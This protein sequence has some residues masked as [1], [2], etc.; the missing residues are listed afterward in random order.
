MVPRKVKKG[1]QSRLIAFGL[2]HV[3]RRISTG[4]KSMI[5]TR[6]ELLS[7]I[8]TLQARLDDVEARAEAAEEALR[9]IQSGEVDAL[10]VYGED[11]DHVYT[12]EG[13]DRT[14]RVMVESVQ[15]GVATLQAEGMLLYA[16]QRLA[17]ML[18]VPLE[19]LLGTSLVPFIA[20]A[21]QNIY[22]GLLRKGKDGL[23]KG[24]M[25]LRRQDGSTFPALLSLSEVRN[26][27]KRVICLVATDL[28]EQ[29]R[30]EEILA[31]E[32]LSRSILEQASEAVVVCDLQ[33]MI[34]R[35]N[36]ATHD[37]ARD[38]P[39]FQSFEKIF[40]LVLG[41]REDESVD[42]SIGAVIGGR[43]F[44][45]IEARLEWAGSS[46]GGPSRIFYLLLSATPLY[47]DRGQVTGCVI[48]LVDITGRT[49][50]EDALKESEKKYR[51]LVKYA[52][53]GI[54]EIDFR[55]KKFTSVNDA[56]CQLSG[57]TRDELLEMNPFDLLDEDGRI[58]FQHRID[59]CLSGEK[60]DE[61][62]EYRV[63][64]KDG[65]EI[66]AI[67]D[68]SF[69][70]DENGKPVI[71]TVIGTDITERKKAEQALLEATRRAEENQ[72]ILEAVIQQMPAGIILSDALGTTAKNNTAMDRIWRRAMLR[73][74]NPQQHG[75]RAFH[76]DGREYEL[77]EWPLTRAL[78]KGEVTLGEEM[79]ILRGDGTQGTVHVS[80]APIRDKSGKIIAG[81]VIDVD[82]SER[83]EMEEQLAYQAGL[84]AQVQD[85]VIANDEQMRITYWNKVAE[86]TFGW[87]EAEALGKDGTELLQIQ[88]PG[89]LRAS[90]MQQALETGR[91]EGEALFRRKDGVYIDVHAK[92]T[93]MKG[94]HGEFKGLVTSARDITR[95]KQAENALRESEQLYRAIGESIDYG[96]WVC[97]PD[98]RNLYAS[99]SFLQ[100]VGITQEQCS[101]FGW[102]DTLH[103]DDAERTIASWRECV[104]TGGNWD[105][106]HRFRGVDGKYHTV[107]A[108]GVPVR[109][110]QGKIIYWAGINLDINRIK[111]AE[112]A[113]QES[114]EKYRDLAERITDPLTAWDSKLRCIYQN[115]AAHAATSLP[116]ERVLGKSFDEIYPDLVGTD[117]HKAYL[118]S[119]ETR[120]PQSLVTQWVRPA[121]GQAFYFL[122]NLYPTRN[123]IT[124]FSRDI[125]Q[126]KHAEAAIQHQTQ[127]TR[128]INRILEG[129]IHDPTEE[130][131]GCTCLAIVEELTGSRFGFIDEIG[132]GGLLHGL[133]ISS[134]EW[135]ASTLPD[136]TGH[137]KSLGNFLIQDIYR[138]VLEDGKSLISNTLASHP[139]W[140][141]MPDCHPP[142]TAFLGVPLI[143]NGNVIGIIAVANREN[144]Y[145][146][147]QQADLEILAPAVI[148][149]LNHVR[150]E[151]AL[152]ESEARE[153]TRAAELEAIMAAV[154]AYMWT[155]HDPQAREMTGNRATFDLMRIQPGENLSKTG[156]DSEKVSHFK[157]MRAGQEI[158]AEQ[159]PVQLA[160]ATGKP[161]RDYEFE[162]ALAGGEIRHLL[163]NAEPLLDEHRL[164]AGA[165]S[166]FIDITQRK[167]AEL[168]LRESEKRYRKLVDLSPF[169]IFIQT[170]GR[171]MFANPAGLKLFGAEEAGQLIGR[172]VLELTHP[173]HREIQAARIRTTNEEEASVPPMEGKFLRLD[174]T[175]IQVESASAPIE[176]EGHLGALVVARDISETRANQLALLQS[177]EDQRVAQLHMEVQRRLL[178]QREQE[179]Q[180]IARDLH[181]GPLQE[182]I[183]VTFTLQAMLMDNCAPE[184][185]GPLKAIRTTLQEQIN[186]LRAYAGEL[187]PPTL[188]TFG[189]V[190]AIRSHLETFQ[191]KHPELQLHLEQSWKGSLL[192][193]EIRLTIFRIYQESLVNIAK[194]ARATEVT[195]Q[196][197]KTENQIILE[198]E[199]N[200]V[201]FKVPKDWLDLIQYKHLG[202]VGMRE[203][204]EAIGGRLELQSKPG[205]GTLLILIVPVQQS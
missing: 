33:G 188:V 181:D 204:A 5:Q 163:G 90:T 22:T 169:A 193:E 25:T 67:L 51:E 197:E 32:R 102:G 175:P 139:D 36:Q 27:G 103:P 86:E 96:V 119:L 73:D 195:I 19:K 81:V 115:R 165:V 106:E 173:E 79:T 143:L 144:G 48:T 128:A 7:T 200:G 158:P 62:V 123:G 46:A 166:A 37:L 182:L 107:L 112:Q 148:E 183:A 71:A 92:S 150:A 49:Q 187:R 118:H 138:Q 6:E 16:N 54:Y 84:L 58:T 205:E 68:A 198:I 30:H 11:G 111:E 75:Y 41:E 136:K 149:A 83:K 151:R 91:Y 88:I 64:A 174:G 72:L 60:P 10:V 157:I 77:G 74:E 8:E 1:P 82:I 178:D 24:E 28:S 196:L 171:F 52:P 130:Q 141:D 55:E 63:K 43:S 99:P 184:I 13:A 50:I 201:G 18:G 69:K 100:L 172:S 78:V 177:Q 170:G 93:V 97:A 117:T 132:P 109:D 56:M 85:A 116:D 65:H 76:T 17:E 203:R 152:H 12:L 47:N 44:S 38:N 23:S 155:T 89:S 59:Q 120:Q 114:E 167:Q 42:F 194:H 160:A 191:K 15:E 57:Y 154:P 176:Y 179:R 145:G 105:I 162:I 9:A 104:R 35:T 159:L 164:P 110:E 202:L 140:V 26:P 131:L 185:A 133:A 4:N 153:R 14:Y 70:A 124:A 122:L 98:G 40:P 3:I 80:S 66:Y 87:T 134:P 34:I 95:R 45:G 101:E 156:P 21:E 129:T 186:E 126:R 127:L 29:K 146:P 192:S 199:D 190:K 189:L 135:E 53:T 61:S 147:E 2:D 31:A 137:R 180:Q 113:L 121:D 168:A 94:P 39:L 125:T 142:L 20:P 108:R 161:V